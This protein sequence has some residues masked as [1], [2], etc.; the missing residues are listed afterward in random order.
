MQRY[1]REVVE[2]PQQGIVNGGSPSDDGGGD[3]VKRAHNVGGDYSD[4][5]SCESSLGSEDDKGVDG[6]LWP[7]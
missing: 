7:Q 5:D 1:C 2:G 4:L 3:D 6:E